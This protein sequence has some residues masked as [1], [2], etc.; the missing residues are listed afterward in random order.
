MYEILL[1]PVHGKLLGLT[2]EEL[3]IFYNTLAMEEISHMS[4]GEAFW[5]REYVSVKSQVED[6]ANLTGYEV[7]EVLD[8][9]EELILNVDFTFSTSV[10]YLTPYIFVEKDYGGELC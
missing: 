3:E 10:I 6:L 1:Y 9:L 8:I 2:N 7:Y 4:L 5:K